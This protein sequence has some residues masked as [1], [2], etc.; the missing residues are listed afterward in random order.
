[1][2]RVIS[3]FVQTDEGTAASLKPWTDSIKERVGAIQINITHNEPAKMH[4]HKKKIKIKEKEFIAE[5][6]KA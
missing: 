5:F 4:Q 2:R 1:M 3:L 6:D